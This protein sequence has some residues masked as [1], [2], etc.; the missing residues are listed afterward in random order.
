VK[1]VWERKVGS[2]PLV[3]PTLGSY[4]K[5]DDSFGRALVFRATDTK[6]M[7]AVTSGG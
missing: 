3:I 2:G 1:T 7:R 5:L 4:Y 6:P